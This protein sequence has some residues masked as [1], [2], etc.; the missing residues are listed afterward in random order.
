[1]SK[2]V[3]YLIVALVLGV[4]GASW[5]QKASNPNPADGATDVVMMLLRWTPGPTA[6][7]HDVYL[8][9]TPELGPEHLVAPKN[10]TGVYFDPM[11]VVSGTTYYWRVDAIDKIDGTVY[12][13]DVWSFLAQ[14]LTAFYP[15]PADGSNEVSP[16]PAL[17]WL[18]GMGAANHQVYFSDSFADVNDGTAA[19][20]KGV[21][22]DPN[23]TPGELEELTTYYWR[24]DEIGL[25]GNVVRGDVWSFITY[26]VVDDF[27]SYNDDVEAGTTIFDTWIDGLTN[28]TGS[29]IGY[30]EAPFCEQTVV[31]GGLQSMPFEYRNGDSPWYS[32]GERDFGASQDWT[33]NDANGLTLYVQGRVG[34]FV[35]PRVGTPPV[36]D[37]EVDEVWLQASVQV[38]ETRIDG[39][40]P[41]GPA[42]VSG[43][44]RALYDSDNLYVLVDVNDEA[45]VQD[46]DAAQ[47]WLDD[48]V[49]V[50]I[51]G[52]NSK[53]DAQDGVNDYQYCFRWNHG[54]VETPVEWYRSPASL[55]GVQYGVVTTD[56][57][58]RLEI[59]L[60]WLTMIG[61]SAEA[62]QV[63][64]IDVMIDDDD[65]GG[66]RDT[67][68]AWHLP[69]GS[70]HTP[71]LWGTALL[72][73][74]P[75]DGAD[76]L[77]VALGDSSNRIGIVTHPDPEI[78]KAPQWTAWRI[79]LSDFRDAGVNLAA[80]RK[81]FVGVGDPADPK[82]GGS[83]VIFIDDIYLTRPAP[84]TEE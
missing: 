1:M 66:D 83:G 79:P 22:T 20:D 4:C 56:S 82:P 59:K 2:K 51:D 24:V 33:A 77:Y 27:E 46:S 57:G 58:Y 9:T 44:F 72:A 38:I 71:S 28:N 23:F 68:V 67:Q 81:L 80:V 74:P 6:I 15:E 75:V 10:S 84:M 14:P 7:F 53:D 5:G 29:T 43:Q 34:D 16:A 62:S 61:G 48:R 69:S 25:G 50:F 18:E 21:L 3:G 73:E 65:D 8:G 60:P 54:E 40:E 32:E 12:T 11:G 13:G 31:H 52:D 45:L 64:G 78:I 63:I 26:A 49:E 70:P 39:A 36:L 35:I 55:A 76:F 37:G 47:G 19:A 42:D 41:T 30:W 17:T